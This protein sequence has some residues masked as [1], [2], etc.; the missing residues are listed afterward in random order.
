MDWIT[1]GKALAM[2]DAS[3]NIDFGAE[4]PG[5]AGGGLGGTEPA[6]T[7]G[8]GGGGAGSVT[9]GESLTDTSGSTGGT[10]GTVG[11]ARVGAMLVTAPRLRNRRSDG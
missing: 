7:G 9:G 3:P 11:P 5:V 1:L 4:V 10:S 6:T 2:A 8:A